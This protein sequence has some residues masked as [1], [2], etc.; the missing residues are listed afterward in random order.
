[1]TDDGKEL[2]ACV[3]HCE[4]IAELRAGRGVRR[5]FSR[6][7]AGGKRRH[8]TDPF[9]IVDDATQM[10]VHKTLYPF[11]TTKKMP[12]FTATVANSVPSTKL[13]H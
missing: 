10:A 6:G 5:N 8:F 4:R 12:N 2:R 9:Q 3:F 1:V 7:G 13:L 11:Y